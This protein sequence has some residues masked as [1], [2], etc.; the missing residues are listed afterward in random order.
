MIM[1]LFFMVMKG[2]E[3]ISHKNFLLF[4]HLEVIGDHKA[5]R[6]RIPLSTKY[7]RIIIIITNYVVNPGGLSRHIGHK[8]MKKTLF[9]FFSCVFWVFLAFQIEFFR[10]FASWQKEKKAFQGEGLKKLKSCMLVMG[11]SL[12]LFVLVLCIYGSKMNIIFMILHKN[13]KP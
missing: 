1:F 12:G 6:E 13:F 8:N 10:N 5:G 4:S 2:S 9:L 3:A 11:R 7:I